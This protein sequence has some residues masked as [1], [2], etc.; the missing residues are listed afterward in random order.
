MSCFC[1]QGPGRQITDD[2]A[3]AR[4][5]KVALAKNLTVVTAETMRDT[6]SFA[7]IKDIKE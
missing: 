5:H 6:F 3:H 7:P 2:L 4:W 1:P